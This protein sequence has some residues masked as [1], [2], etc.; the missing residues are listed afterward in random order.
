MSDTCDQDFEAEKEREIQGDAPQ[1]ID[2][3][4]PGWGSW[5]GRGVRKPKNKKPKFTKHIAGIDAAA[6]KDAGLN[7]VILSEKRERQAAKYLVK[8]LPHPYISSSQ[9][10]QALRVPLGPEW[11]TG[12]THRSFTRPQVL[13]RMG[14]VIDP[15]SKQE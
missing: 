14:Q 12:S 7:H 13:T 3:T 2:A 6:R 1:D 10:E 4:I 15:I 8:D 5:G 11:Q 9:H